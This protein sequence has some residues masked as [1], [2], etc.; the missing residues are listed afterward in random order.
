MF[1]NARLYRLQS[2]WPDSEESLSRELA[3]AGFTR[4]GP[5]TE[6][7]SGWV[8]I[9]Q[10]FGESLARRLNGADLLRL[11]SQSRVLPPAAI[12]EALQERVD[13]YRQRMREAP[14]RRDK[15]RFKAEIRD[16]LMPKALLKS[17]RIWG[18]V[19]LADKLIVIDTA[20][21]SAA[22]RFLRDLRFPFGT[23]EIRP[24]KFKTPVTELL[25]QIL[26]RDAPPRF[27][28]GR[29][30]RMQDA[31]EHRSNVRWTDFD[32]TDKSIRG[33]VADGMRLTHLAIEYDNILSC[34]I[35]ENGVIS[36]MRFL[37]MD[38]KETDDEHDPLARFD[39][40]FVL[41]SGTLRQML[42]DLKNLLDGFA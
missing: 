36:K 17:D 38:D 28:V 10:D 35:D 21:A 33:H 2:D 15:R 7:S 16:E 14:G 5:L 1:R 6:R 12:N 32:L 26:L 41:L 37:G 31:V 4:C 11:R 19:D 39:A 27:A 24:L 22:E 20:Q 3:K 8:A 18:Y 40:E 30:C 42:G 13:D 9:D 25:T 23:L 29:E 34:V